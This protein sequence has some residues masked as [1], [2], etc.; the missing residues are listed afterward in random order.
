MIRIPPRTYS[1]NLP[2][3]LTHDQLVHVGERSPGMCRDCRELGEACLR[4]ENDETENQ[5]E[6]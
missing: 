1:S 2:D 3:G 4:H 5:E 6:E